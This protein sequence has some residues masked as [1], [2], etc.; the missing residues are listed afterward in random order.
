MPIQKAGNTPGKTKLKKKGAK[1]SH[2]LRS[3]TTGKA[4]AQGTKK[5][6]A[7]AAGRIAGFKAHGGK[8]W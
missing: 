1:G 3:P 8:K 6:V 2:V 4:L 5:Q 7:K